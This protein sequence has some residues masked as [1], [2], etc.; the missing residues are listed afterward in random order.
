MTYKPNI[1][2]HKKTIIYIVIALLILGLLAFSGNKAYRYIKGQEKSLKQEI[3]GL[4]KSRDSLFLE[5]G[6][7]EYKIDS[8]LSQKIKNYKTEYRRERRRRINLQNKLKELAD[9]EFNRDYLDSLKNN[10]YY[11]N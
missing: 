5:V 3:K 2:K 6:E 10:V 1:S 8:I 11:E 7:R 4:E 9:K